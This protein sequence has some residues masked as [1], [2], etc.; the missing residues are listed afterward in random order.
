M[1]DLNRIRTRRFRIF[2]TVSL[3]WAVYTSSVY[4][5]VIVGEII[6]A[7]Y[8]TV[9][10]GHWYAL[11][12][13]KNSVISEGVY[14]TRTQADAAQYLW[15]ST[16][17]NNYATIQ[18]TAQ[19]AEYLSM[20][21]MTYNYLNNYMQFGIIKHN[22][23]LGHTII[24]SLSY[25]SGNYI[26]YDIRMVLLIGYGYDNNGTEYI[27]YHEPVDGIEEVCSFD[28]FINGYYNSLIYNRTVYNDGGEER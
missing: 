20:N 15:G 1:R 5:T 23:D 18:E 7:N 27:Y 3:V 17:I 12:C 6:S 19:A 14:T 9:L 11:A 24:A 21:S 13:A 8:E 25:V 10:N 22:I 4:A 28:Q 16:L 26:S 2:L